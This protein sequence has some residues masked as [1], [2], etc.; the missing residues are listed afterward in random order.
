MSGG[1]GGGASDAG[2]EGVWWGPTEERDERTPGTQCS[3]GASIAARPLLLAGLLQRQSAACCPLPQHAQE[4]PVRYSGP[5]DAC[6]IGSHGRHEGVHLS[7]RLLG[8][9]LLDHPGTHGHSRYPG[10]PEA[11]VD[12]PPFLEEEVDASRRGERW[13]ARP[14]RP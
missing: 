13:R 10:G 14:R 2:G 9:E 5:D 7:I 4:H 12:L 11:R 3:P 1:W 6:H 8:D